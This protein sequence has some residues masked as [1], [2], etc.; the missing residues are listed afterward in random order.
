MMVLDRTAKREALKL[1]QGEMGGRIVGNKLLPL[2]RQ[3]GSLV[4]QEAVSCDVGGSWFAVEAEPKQANLAV[5]SI[6]GVG[7]VA[8]LPKVCATY[9]VR[10]RKRDVERAMFGPYFFTRC[11][12]HPDDWHKITAA[13]GVRRL[14]GNGHPHEIPEGA[15]EVV[16]FQEADKATLLGRTKFVHHFSPGDVV[17]ITDGPFASF[18]AQ[19]ESAVDER[20]RIKALV[21]IFGRKSPCEFEATQLQPL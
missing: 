4:R 19:L 21:D 20:G 15:I 13:R 6:A 3:L 1:L 8:Y 5:Q 7:L 17:R 18:Y 2:E 10:G 9:M 12:A 14:L 16:R 11:R